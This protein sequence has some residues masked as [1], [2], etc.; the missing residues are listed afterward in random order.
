MQIIKLLRT[1]YEGDE[2]LVESGGVYK[3][4]KQLRSFVCGSF[5]DRIN[6]RI[7]TL[8]QFQ[9]RFILP[10]FM[11]F[12]SAE[13]LFLFPYQGEEGIDRLPLEDGQ[14]I[15]IAMQLID[16]ME[17]LH[18][19]TGEGFGIWG[20]PHLLISDRLRIL[21]P[22]WVNFNKEALK[23]V[24]NRENVFIAPEILEGKWPTSASDTYVLGKILEN[25]LPDDFKI[26]FSRELLQMTDEDPKARPSHFSRLFTDKI[27]ITR[28]T[29]SLEGLVKRDLVSSHIVERDKDLRE[30]NT[31]FADLQ[32]EET[33][34]YLVYGGSRVGK[35]TFLNLIQ[36]DMINNGWKTLMA[37]DTKHFCQELLQITENPEFAGVNLEDFHYLWD[38]QDNYNLD[39][40]ARIVGKLIGIMDQIAILVD[41][42]EQIDDGF[43]KLLDYVQSMIIPS[44]VVIIAA[45]TQKDGKFTFTKKFKLEPF[46]KEQTTKFL[47]ILLGKYFTTNYEAQVKWIYSLTNG[48]PGL[49]YNF[50]MLL[51]STD[52]LNIKEG[53]W[54]IEGN[55][56]NIHG[57]EDY[58]ERLFQQIDPVDKNL[59]SIFS[60]L[61]ENFLKGEFTAL[62][63]IVG[64]DVKKAEASLIRL[65]RAGLIIKEGE[66]YRFTL[67]DIWEK[68]YKTLD[69]DKKLKIHSSF[70]KVSPDYSRKAW[71]YSQTGKRRAAAAM[72]IRAGCENFK[73]NMSWAIVEQYFQ[74][75]YDLLDEGEISDEIL[76]LPAMLKVLKGEI[77]SE[78]IAQRLKHSRRLKYL[79]LYNLVL[80]C[81]FDKVEREYYQIYPDHKNPLKTFPDF[82]NNL[83]FV[84]SLYE[85]GKIGKAYD[86]IKVVHQN[87]KNF[88]R[89]KYLN[90]MFKNLLAKIEWRNNRWDE[91]AVL[92][93]ENMETAEKLEI[94][95]LLPIV[96]SSLG[97]IMDINGPHYSKPIL[98]KA[99][100]YSELYGIPQLS[101]RPALNLANS[102]LY[103]GDITS[104]FIFIE[105]SREISRTYNDRN[106]LALS[107]L[108]E[109]LYHLY[110]KQY[111]EAMEDLD[112]A[113]DK[114][115]FPE[116]KQ[117]A[118]RFKYMC[119]LSMGKTADIDRSILQEPFAQ[120]YGF[121]DVIKL[122]FAEDPIEIKKYFNRFKEAHHL[123]KE[124]IAVAFKEK[125]SKN[126]PEEFER[127]LESL[128]QYY[129]KSH[130]KLPIALTN[131][132]FA[133]L[134]REMGQYR[135]SK[136]FARNAVDMYKNMKMMSAAEKLNKELLMGE[137]TLE[138]YVNIISNALRS[139]KR[140]IIL[141]D[142]L[143]NQFESNLIA[144]INE[145]DV[146][147]E[148][149]NFSK[150]ITASAE[151]EEILAEF[152]SWILSFSPIRKMIIAVLKDNKV[153]YKSW[154]SLTSTKK[155]EESALVHKMLK[156]KQGFIRTPFEAKAE[157]F[158]DETYKVMLYAE[159]TNLMM[160][161]EEFDRF[162]LFIDNLEPIISM[163]IRNAISYRSSILDPLTGLYTRWYYTR[164]LEEEFDKSKRFNS[165]L[166]VIMADLDHFKRVNDEYGHNVGDEVLK[167]ISSILK[168]SVRGYDVV[169]RYGGEEFVVILPDTNLEEAKEVAERIRGNVEKCNQFNFYLTISLG[170]TS[171][172]EKEYEKYLELVADADRALYYSKNNG[173]NQVTL[174]NPKDE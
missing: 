123:W 76:M 7:K 124:E 63:S 172:R 95:F 3:R 151:P 141:T 92:C 37:G 68:A 30:F 46:S 117:K 164:R 8:Y 9:N 64:I 47:E 134:Y 94:K 101:L 99:I 160:S 21:P 150:T 40:V 113:I 5:Q 15:E 116:I 100:K 127:Y 132:A 167:T 122:A 67:H 54:I 148:I 126:F 1:N 102:Y 163:A 59:L 77:L 36:T 152:V 80:K 71:H 139:D 174:Y 107:Y 48:Y 138:D 106:N 13:P 56:H 91:S 17:L 6:S 49:I 111:K 97:T 55:I 169:G 130:L 166:S 28:A 23:F 81:E 145:M 78:K 136:K 156:K 20:F 109:G 31:Y 14:K 103:S 53:K 114:V 110:N 85:S 104:M 11:D 34:S 26:K 131:E 42:F 88:N 74:N 69:D 52:K 19:V 32:N 153:I 171:T 79:Y 121:H 155:T 75:A 144:K 38:L 16:S 39:R 118:R 96:Y 57:M 41:D 29:K 140:E 27:Q 50:L 62:C 33:G 10:D 159:N 98:Q 84:F 44:K 143:L 112:K 12:N 149:I 45:S 83:S 22:L 147:H 4:S 25:L 120:D 165:N 161:N 24:L 72:Y 58:V 35:T 157:F 66:R 65:Q 105:K 154:I 142:D 87:M 137:K 93:K 173:R 128:I 60:G 2:Y 162:A 70:C 73:N 89:Y 90:I 86:E 115:D 158:V 125:L 168:K 119:L 146:L 61:S 133:Y 135:K 170:V 43:R 108:I 18:H 51:N 129:L 82:T